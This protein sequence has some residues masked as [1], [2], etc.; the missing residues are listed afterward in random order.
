[1]D[2]DR[3]PIL[4]H[5]R[6]GFCTL[7]FSSA[8]STFSLQSHG[9]VDV[10]GETHLAGPAAGEGTDRI[11]A[12]IHGNAARPEPSGAHEAVAGGPGTPVIFQAAELFR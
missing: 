4:T 8:A 10:D 1:M 11:R 7:T 5:H 12:E 6:S 2:A 3:P 9:G